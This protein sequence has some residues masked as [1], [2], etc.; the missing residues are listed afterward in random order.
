MPGLSAPTR[1]GRPCSFATMPY[2]L[3]A[4]HAATQARARTGER[5]VMRGIGLNAALAVLKIAA[6][7]AGHAYALIAD[8]AESAI[9]VVSS[10]LAWVAFRV[11][12]QPPDEEH[13]Y[14]H[15][16]AEPL[17]AFAVAGIT[18]VAILW[19]GWRSIHFIVTPHPGPHW[20]T[21]PLVAGAAAAKMALSRR[22][23]EAGK[24][25]GSTALAT[26]AWHQQADAI[27]SGAAFA[28]IA[29][30]VAGGRGWESADD[31]AALLACVVIG[32]GGI[33]RLRSALGEMMDTAAPVSL[34]NEVRAIAARVA[35]VE[36]LDKCRVRKSGLSN[37]VDIQIRVHG[38]LTVHAG[39]DIAHAVKDA[40]LASALRISDVSV[41]VE[42][43]R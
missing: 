33:S 41:H 39:H 34:E 13:P 6:G 28:G 8:G 19:I 30:A 29:V 1:A 9:D 22:M 26:E 18:L 20:G 25:S 5:L 16:R 24:A 12:G 32:T 38:D 23:R 14:G 35:G 21:L 17:A 42:P 43:M 7:F 31:W 4:H 11:A 10:V 15:G 2:S 27:V 36:A 3:P 37:L 40:L